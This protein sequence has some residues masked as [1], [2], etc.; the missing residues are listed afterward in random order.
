MDS[1]TSAATVDVAVRRFAQRLREEVGADRVLLFGS[2]ASGTAKPDSDYDI[3]I[4]AGTFRSVPKF[5]RGL[6]LRDLYYE[7]G[8]DAPLDLFRLTP[9]EFDYASTHITLVNAVLPEAID[10]LQ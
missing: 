6:G 1:A 5:K 7:V 8:G 4:V 3:I 2:Q 9:E 10:L